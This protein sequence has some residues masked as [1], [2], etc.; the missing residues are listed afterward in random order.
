M[1]N[2]EEGGDDPKSDDWTLKRM[3]TW[4]GMPRVNWKTQSCPLVLCR[5]RWGGG[6]YQG[7]EHCITACDLGSW[8][9]GHNRNWAVEPEHMESRQ[10][11]SS[12][13][14]LLQARLPCR[15]CSPRLRMRRSERD[16]QWKTEGSWLKKQTVGGQKRQMRQRK[17]HSFVS[18][19]LLL[20]LKAHLTFSSHT[21][22][23]YDAAQL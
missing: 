19:K 13:V 6:E 12:T 3:W 10:K 15:P 14:Q 5:A 9:P 4:M 7:G 20:I 23:E 16:A 1:L 2:V 22:A 21:W 17:G 8:G 11:N 18:D